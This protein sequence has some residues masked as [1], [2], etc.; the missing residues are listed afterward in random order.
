MR[1]DKIG[2]I[3]KVLYN[4]IDGRKIVC[5]VNDLLDICSLIT[6][7]L[8]GVIFILMKK[9]LK[10][11]EDILCLSSQL[12]V[13]EGKKKVVYILFQSI[14][15]CNMANIIIFPMMFV[16][17]YSIGIA[18]L[19]RI[20]CNV[21]F[22]CINMFLILEL[23]RRIFIGIEKFFELSN[24]RHT[25]KAC[26]FVGAVIY[27]YRYRE[28]IIQKVIMLKC[29]NYIWLKILAIFAYI[30]DKTH[31]IV[32]LYLSLVLS[33]ALVVII[34][35]LPDR[36]DRDKKIF[37]NIRYNIENIVIIQ[38]LVKYNTMLYSYIVSISRR[39]DT[40][41]MFML[42]FFAYIMA[43]IIKVDNPIFMVLL[44][45]VTSLFTYVQTEAIRKMQYVR[46]Y[47]ARRDYLYMIVS[48][49]IYFLIAS[50]SFSLISLIRGDSLKG[51][52][53]LY[54]IAIFAIILFTFIGIKFAK[55]RDNSVMIIRGLLMASMGV[56]LLLMG[57][58]KVY[59]NVF[60]RILFLIFI[61]L[62]LVKY[63]IAVLEKRINE[64]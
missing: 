5:G 42:T 10:K 44:L 37:M 35:L 29:F 4:A 63:S 43:I 39:I 33:I 15:V 54:V 30:M 11:R 2:N 3:I 62:C 32:S 25:I 23:I 8:T 40:M 58:N 46:E 13:S 45:T 7:V 17:I 52:I 16:G 26:I 47:N 50:I 24:V 41:G 36:I 64:Y 55:L 57:F 9:K 56:G 27:I 34:Y 53:L 31:F 20:L 1:H 49:I 6:I 61:M 22:T 51:I 19:P 12:Q 18:S 28:F 38:R 60:E 14:I 59:M 21:V 48:Q